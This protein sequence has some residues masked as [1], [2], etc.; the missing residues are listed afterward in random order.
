MDM[1][2]LNRWLTLLANIGILVGLIL[3]GYEIRQN[4]ALVRAQI[5]A[6]AFSD[7]KALMIAQMGDDY[8]RALAQS[9][10]ESDSLTIEDVAVL[11]SALEAQLIEFRR[12]ALMEEIG[13]FTGR[14][15]QDISN[16]SRPFTTPIGRKFWDFNYDDKIDWMREVQVAIE[17]TEMTWESE[18]LRA[19]QKSVITDQPR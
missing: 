1:D 7:Q 4:S 5:V 16:L 6:T 8:P 15:R 10:D 9:V 18:Y 12:D 13:V 3:V 17:N 19:L 14:W 11:Q 2:R